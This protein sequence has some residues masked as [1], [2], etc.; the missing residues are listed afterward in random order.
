MTRA[1]ILELRKLTKTF[2]AFTAVNAIDLTIAEGEFF[3]IVGP[4]GSGKTTMIRMLAGMETPSSGD[5]LL[6]GQRINHVPANK[7]PTCMV[8]PSLALFPHRT[9]GQNIEFTLKIRGV[10]IIWVQP[11]DMLLRGLGVMANFTDL[12][13]TP[14]GQDAAAL[15]GNVYGISPRLWNA[16][17]YWEQGGGSLRVS[18]NRTNGAASSGPGQNGITGAQFFGTTRDQWDLSASYTFLDLSFQPQ[19][20]LNVLNLTNNESRTNFVY[21]NAPYEIY[22]PG[23]SITVGLR[24]T[25]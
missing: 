14:S 24:G 13:L 4:S 22:N 10:E 20:T 23:R 21:A 2:A 17:A 11:L 25:F 12:T 6:R 3:T 7:R 15:G 16:T 9:V 19:L 5:I 8:F 1:P 18:Y